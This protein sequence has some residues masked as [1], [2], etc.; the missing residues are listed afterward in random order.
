MGMRDGFLL[1]ILFFF[2]VGLILFI[3]G[4]KMTSENKRLKSFSIAFG[5]VLVLVSILAGIVG[6]IYGIAYF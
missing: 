1:L 5:L 3:S 6:M 4:I 2:F